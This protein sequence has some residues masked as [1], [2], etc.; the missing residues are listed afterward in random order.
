MLIR[1]QVNERKAREKERE[2]KEKWTKR[3][4]EARKP[5]Q[6]SCKRRKIETVDRDDEILR[7]VGL[8]RRDVLG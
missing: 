1:S 3:W 2:A 4:G 6:R 8:K 7:A 5:L